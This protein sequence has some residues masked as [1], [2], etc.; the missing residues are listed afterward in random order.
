MNHHRHILIQQ[1]LFKNL[2]NVNKK[3]Y[4]IY[5]IKLK[6][7]IRG[8]SEVGW[9]PSPEKDQ[10]IESAQ[11]I[12]SY[13]FYILLF[14]VGVRRV[15]G[16]LSSGWLNRVCRGT[17]GFKLEGRLKGKMRKVGPLK[18][19]RKLTAFIRFPHFQLRSF[20]ALKYVTTTH[21]K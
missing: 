6:K 3:Q 11:F 16:L 10:K 12:L 8:K 21:F 14:L 13:F 4:G 5:W 18:Q 20:D 7:E 15:G 9:S 1:K 2:Q 17:L 19:R